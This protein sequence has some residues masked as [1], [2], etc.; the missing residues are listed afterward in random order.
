MRN[1]ANKF[2]AM[3]KGDIFFITNSDENLKSMMNITAAQSLYDVPGYKKV[4][5]NLETPHLVYMYMNFPLFFEQMIAAGEADEKSRAFFESDSVKML[6][7]MGMSL[8]PKKDGVSFKLVASGNQEAMDKL[9]M[10]FST[11][12]NSKQYMTGKFPALNTIMY[13]EIYNLK[14]IVS[15][16]FRSN[17][18]AYSQMAEG[19]EMSRI[20][21]QQA[22]NLDLQKDFFDLFDK[23]FALAV[24]YEKGNLIPGLSILVDAKGHEESARKVLAAL[25]LGMIGTMASIRESTGSETFLTKEAVQVNGQAM[26]LVK[27]NLMEALQDKLANIPPAAKSMIEKMK[28]E[29]VYGLDANGVMVLSTIGNLSEKYGKSS[30]TSE[31]NIKQAWTYITADNQGAFYFDLQNVLAY[32]EEMVKLIDQ[33]EPMSATEKESYD[34]IVNMLKPIRYAIFSSQSGPYDSVA[35]GFIKI[36]E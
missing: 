10:R 16:S 34:R 12:P 5:S 20:Q 31:P 30:L 1:P 35:T 27:L 13:E 17:P 21:I 4:L 11:T 25:D 15:N 32:A 7:G 28:V 3:L 18:A 6:E 33:M 23:G 2:Y 26:V 9:S 29:F 24:Q 14:E 36:G 8:T 22:L 19:I